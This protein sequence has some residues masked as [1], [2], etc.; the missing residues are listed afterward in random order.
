M[1]SE[2]KSFTCFPYIMLYI[3]HVT[4]GAGPFLTPQALVEVHLVML[5]TKYQGSR[6]CGFRQENYFHSFPKNIY[7]KQLTPRTGA[8]FFAPGL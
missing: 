8:F 4:P 1:V 7:V 3:K 5:N 2:K 6:L